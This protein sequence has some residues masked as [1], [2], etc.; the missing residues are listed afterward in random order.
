MRGENPKP[1]LT[2]TWAE[3][4]AK[5]RS[6]ASVDRKISYHLRYVSIL[7]MFLIQN[8]FEMRHIFSI[9]QTNPNMPLLSSNKSC[10]PTLLLFILIVNFI[11]DNGPEGWL[12]IAN[13]QRTR[14]NTRK[15]FR[16]STSPKWETRHNDS[17]DA[18][19]KR[20]R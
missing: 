13:R 17:M 9:F 19:C 3:H 18:T 20:L 4:R 2:L 10:N 7:K 6:N 5:F 1:N 11:P 15:Q 12:E 16:G 8:I 14:R